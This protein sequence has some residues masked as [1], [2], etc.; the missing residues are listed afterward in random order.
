MKADR[1]AKRPFRAQWPKQTSLDALPFV[2]LGG[3]AVSALMRAAVAFEIDAVIIAILSGLLFWTQW[4][5][6][7]RARAAAERIE[8]L[9]VRRG[10]GPLSAEDIEAIQALRAQ[11]RRLAGRST[12]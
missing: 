11:A 2:V 4:R 8:R 10:F 3:L 9:L 6:R 7:R 12:T 1:G 5:E